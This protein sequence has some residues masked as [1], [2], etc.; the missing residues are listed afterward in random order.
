MFFKKGKSI[1]LRLSK[2]YQI[3]NPFLSSRNFKD[4]VFLLE[5]IFSNLLKL[6]S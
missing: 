6:A 5:D 2:R 1:F 3:V 4:H